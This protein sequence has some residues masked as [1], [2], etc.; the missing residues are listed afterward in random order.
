MA[1]GIR[2]FPTLEQT[3]LPQAIQDEAGCAKRATIVHL[4]VCARHQALTDVR[5]LD[6][7]LSSL[8]RAST[9]RPR[10]RLWT[11]LPFTP[12]PLHCRSILSPS[13]SLLLLFFFFLMMRRPPRSTL[14]PNPTLFR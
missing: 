11:L 1:N 3:D 5:H 6:T 13:P 14:F 7:R 10:L 9:W 8:V 12:S 2:P 4:L